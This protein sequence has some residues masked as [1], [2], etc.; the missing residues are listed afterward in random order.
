[1][2]RNR[3]DR[4]SLYANWLDVLT[5][6]VIPK[7]VGKGSGPVSNGD[8]GISAPIRASV[9]PAADLEGGLN[10]FA[11]VDLLPGSST[12]SPKIGVISRTPCYGGLRIL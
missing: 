2:V 8:A 1:M 9:G 11:A 4:D 12:V 3:L 10:F 6:T 5:L 7:V